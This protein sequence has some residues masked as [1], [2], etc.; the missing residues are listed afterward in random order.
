MGSKHI[1]FMPY[2]DKLLLKVNSR[3]KKVSLK[4]ILVLHI[5]C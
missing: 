1:I 3:M 4:Y 5:L 2:I